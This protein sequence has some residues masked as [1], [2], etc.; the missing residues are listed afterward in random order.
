MT[1]VA[2]SY[3]YEQIGRLLVQNQLAL[4]QL[5]LLEARVKDFEAADK[6]QPEPEKEQ[7]PK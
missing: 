2:E 3:L 5:G 1:Q 6:P 7:P 4:A